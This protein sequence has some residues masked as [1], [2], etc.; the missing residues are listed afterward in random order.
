MRRRCLLEGSTHVHN[1]TVDIAGF[2]KTEEP[3]AMGRIIED[4]T[5]GKKCQRPIPSTLILDGPRTDVA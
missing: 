2:L 5:L 3:R 4:V 1:A